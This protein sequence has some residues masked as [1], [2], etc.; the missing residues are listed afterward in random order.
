MTRSEI[1]RILR[2]TPD[3]VM[4]L[5]RGLSAPHLTRQPKQGEWSVT[6]ILNHLLLGE[7]DV[8]L[9]RFKRILHE[10]RPVFPSSLVSR[11]GFAA[12]PIPSDFHTDLAV[13]RRIRDK[14]VNF[15]ETLDERGWQRTGTTPTRG[16]LTLEAYA[17][18]LAEHDLEHLRQLEATRVAM[19]ARSRNHRTL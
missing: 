10:N 17:R 14:T 19:E 8:I 4:E 2:S 7:R 1:L 11:T 9:P 6:E 5:T 16:T 12:A 13:F 18:Y 3:R 15:L